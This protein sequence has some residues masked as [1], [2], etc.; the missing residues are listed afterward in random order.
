VLAEISSRGALVTLA[1]NNL[2]FGQF[3]PHKY[4][5]TDGDGRHVGTIDGQF[6]MRD[7]YEIELDDTSTVPKEPILA[8]AMVIDAI[9][10][11]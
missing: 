7:R 2:P 3:I 11:H 6:S 10:N 1:R 9:Q 4:E 5:I 8:A